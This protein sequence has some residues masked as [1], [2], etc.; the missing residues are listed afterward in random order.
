MRFFFFLATAR[1]LSR[2]TARHKQNL[3]D[4]EMRTWDS[5]GVNSEQHNGKPNIKSLLDAT[6]IVRISET[7]EL[8]DWSMTDKL[9]ELSECPCDPRRRH[10]RL[11]QKVAVV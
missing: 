9:I 3:L 10:E 6:P 2:A 7:G 8:Y 11:G 1:N 5:L 4:H